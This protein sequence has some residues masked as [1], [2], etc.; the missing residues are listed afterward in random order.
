[1]NRECLMNRGSFS[2]SYYI[3]SHKMMEKLKRKQPGFLDRLTPNLLRAYDKLY[4]VR[5]ILAKLQKLEL[6]LLN[7]KTIQL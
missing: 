3:K 5:T 7:R 6:Q 1:M 2:R 4:A